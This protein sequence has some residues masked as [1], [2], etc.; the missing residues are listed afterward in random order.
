MTKR[1]DQS[2][3]TKLLL[4]TS[5]WLQLHDHPEIVAELSRNQ[6]LGSIEILICSTNEKELGVEEYKIKNSQLLQTI[7]PIR[8]PDSYFILDETPLGGG[9]LPSE[10]QI[11]RFRTYKPHAPIR[12]R[13]DFII[14]ETA[15]A[16]GANLITGD[17]SSLG[18]LKSS[19]GVPTEMIFPFEALTQLL[20]K[21]GIKG[22]IGKHR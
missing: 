3:G 9:S 11:L 21:L 14:A 18:P 5:V 15:M 8:V 6:L 17:K 4:D 19:G 13:R 7:R 1:Q 2:L 12:S 16:N 10:D 22:E 20:K